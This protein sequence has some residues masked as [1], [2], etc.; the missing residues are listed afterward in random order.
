V[1]ARSGW[2]DG[3]G[4]LEEAEV[5]VFDPSTRAYAKARR[6]DSPCDVVALS[7]NVAALGGEGSLRLSATL[8]RETDV[9]LQLVAGELVWARVHAGPAST[10]SSSASRSS[11]ISSSPAPPTSAPALLASR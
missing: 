5:A 7:G 6:L 2:I 3:V 11:T 8:A 9:G 10:R 1:E 4:T